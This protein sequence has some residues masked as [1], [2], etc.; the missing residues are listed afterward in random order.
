GVLAGLSI[1]QKTFELLDRKT[2]FEFFF[3]DGDSVEPG[4]L[5]ATVQGDVRILLSG[6]RVALNFLQR[7]SGVATYTHRMAKELEGTSTKLVDTRKTTPGLRLL[8]KYAV[9]MGG[10]HNHRYNLDDAIMLKDNHILAAG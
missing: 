7:M 5:V 1:F 8:E 10:G 6:E 4:D 9:R 3:K 2:E